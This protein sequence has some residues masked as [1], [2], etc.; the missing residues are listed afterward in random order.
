MGLSKKAKDK[1]NEWKQFKEDRI[2]PSWD[3]TFITQAFQIAK[4]SL[5][6]QTQNG[7]IL[8][9][10]TN[11]IVTTGYNSF[12]RNIDDSVLPN[13]R[14]PHGINPAKYTW[15]IHAEHN[16]IL[17]ACRQGKSIIDCKA[18]VTGQPCISCFQYMY[19]AGIK[20]VIYTSF[21]KSDM[22]KIDKDYETNV[23]I[24]V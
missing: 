1:I 20:E 14:D 5:D 3:E 17:N 23:E 7:C 6:N 15:T 8:V 21:N 9:T 16:A 19:Q 24:F 4:R 2:R 12:V 11:E 18:Y 13:I 22:T 10:P